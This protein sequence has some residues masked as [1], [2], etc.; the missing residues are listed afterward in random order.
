[1][2]SKIKEIIILSDFIGKDTKGGQ[3]LTYAISILEKLTVENIDSYKLR[4]ILRSVYL[5]GHQD[6]NMKTSDISWED[7]I[8]K[9]ILAALL[10]GLGVK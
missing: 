7:K 6:G 4:L 5:K 9:D 8:V 3:A 2:E 10:E 1:M